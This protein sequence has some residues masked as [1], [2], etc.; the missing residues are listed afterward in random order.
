[1]AELCQ[2]SKVIGNNLL[3]TKIMVRITKN[4]IIIE[5]EDEYP[6]VLL[7]LFKTSIIEVLQNLDFKSP[8]SPDLGSAQYFVLRMLK[9]L[10]NEQKQ[11]K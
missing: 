11:D 1:M 10:L 9:E 6:E 2:L 8:N 7:E 3:A 5:I 4:K